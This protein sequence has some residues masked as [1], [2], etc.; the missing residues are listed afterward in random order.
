MSEAILPKL[1]KQREVNFM[2]RMAM[3]VAATGLAI[4]A[5]M[6]ITTPAEAGYNHIPA[7]CK[8]IVA[9]G[10]YSELN[11][12]ECISLITSEFH[13]LVDGKN[14]NPDAVHSCDFYAEN[15]PDLFDS[16]WD[17]KQQCVAEILSL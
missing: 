3:L 4:P 7:R 11:Q 8:E 9:S 15:A 16:L 10:A 5:Q 2:R 6:T 1:E 12:G 13:Y 17:S 14:G